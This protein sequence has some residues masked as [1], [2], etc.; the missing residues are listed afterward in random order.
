MP[1]EEGAEPRRKHS[2]VNAENSGEFVFNMATYGLREKVKLS[3]SHVPP[4]VDE[5]DLCGLTKVPATLVKPH[6]SWYISIGSR[7]PGINLFGT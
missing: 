6:L 7:D 1:G 4:D 3:S 5:M 2:V